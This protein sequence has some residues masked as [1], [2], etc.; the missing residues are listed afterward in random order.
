[1]S[2]NRLLRTAALASMF[3]I[4][5]ACGS[6]TIT[7][8]DIAGRLVVT[9]R[10]EVNA[11]V[12]D[13]SVELWTDGS[14]A[15]LWLTGRTAATGQVQLGDE[16]MVLIGDYLLKPVVPSGYALANG[17]AASIPV[18]VEADRT[19]SVTVQLRRTP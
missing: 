4:V 16:G 17:Q 9:V 11:P 5:Q 6:D 7:D 8:A 13:V 10:D 15:M 2:I 18:R 19:T 14:P 1:M 3:A 12:A